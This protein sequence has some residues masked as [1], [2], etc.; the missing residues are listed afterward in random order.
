MTAEQI[1]EVIADLRSGRVEVP[2]QVARGLAARLLERAQVPQPVVDCTAVFAAQQAREEIRLYD[3]HPSI[4]PPWQD[5]LLCFVNTFGNVICLQVHRRDW[6]GSTPSREDWFTDN[7]VD[8]ASVRWVAQT[9]VW[10]GGRAG[11]GTYLP[12]SGPCHMFRHAIRADGGPEDINWVALLTPAGRYAGRGELGD[13]NQGTWDAA[14]ITLGAALNFLSC[15]NVD[16]A[17]P[18]RA[19][20]FRRRLE[21]TGVTVQEIVVRAPGKRRAA[22]SEPRPIAADETAFSPVRGHFSRYGPAYGRGLLFGKYEGKF[23]V[24][25]HVRGAGEAEPRDYILKPGS[26]A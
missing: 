20:P 3:D 2:P 17:E 7:E 19:R 9:T 5:A 1:A 22:S 13:P 6:D 8:W 11:N 12:T 10:A 16:I 15:S 26:A 4:T 18:Q 21:R 23:W 25:A 14:M 24:P